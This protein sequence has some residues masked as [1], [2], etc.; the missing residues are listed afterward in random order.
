M[1]LVFLM[2]VQ[3]CMIYKKLPFCQVHNNFID[4]IDGQDLSV[5][6]GTHGFV[7][8][9]NIQNDMN[10]IEDWQFDIGYHKDYF[11]STV[12]YGKLSSP[13]FFYPDNEELTLVV[14]KSNKNID[15][16][17]SNTS[18]IID[19]AKFKV[20]DWYD[21]LWSLVQN[22]FSINRYYS[23]HITQAINFQEK[24]T[25]KYH[26]VRINNQNF[27]KL[28]PRHPL[29]TS[30]MFFPAPYVIGLYEY[31][32]KPIDNYGEHVFGLSSK[33]ENSK[34]FVITIKHNDVI[35]I[36]NIIC[37]YRFKNLA[38]GINLIPLW[39]KTNLRKH[40]SYII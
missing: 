22:P 10:E 7:K 35:L 3:N 17:I 33:T 29:G 1:E 12:D 15:I 34:K 8:I 21:D 5:L 40:F 25:S 19:S 16:E 4:D 11:H 32:E 39:Y 13:L 2:L 18:T 9:E 23:K 6:A 37:Q 24:H 36:D 28:V 26:P 38:K 30:C 20:K 27:I 31:A 14:N